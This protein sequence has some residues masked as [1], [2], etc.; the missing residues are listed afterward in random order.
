MAV[1]RA[2]VRNVLIL[3]AAAALV[4]LPS[5]DV[6]SFDRDEAFTV[7]QVVQPDLGDTLEAIPSET[8][9]PLYYVL[10]WL[11]QRVFGSGEVSMRSLSALA[12]VATVP[13]AYELGR[14]LVSTRAAVIIAALV[15]FN[16]MLFWF[17]QEARPYSLLVFL[18]SV[19]LL[20]TVRSVEKPDLLNLGMWVAASALA[21]ATHWFAAFLILPQA[22]W[23]LVRTK[24]RR[25]VA[26]VV[27]LAVVCA[28]LLPLLIH[29]AGHG[30][31]AWIGIF[32]LGERLESTGEQFLAGPPGA[33]LAPWAAIGGVLCAIG[34]A[35][36]VARAD[37]AER[38]GGLVALAFGGAALLIPLAIDVVGPNYFVDK[39]VMPALVP[40]GLAVAAGLGA[41]RAGPAGIAIAVALCGIS[42]G[43]VAKM[44]FDRDFQRWDWRQAMAAMGKPDRPRAVVAPYNGDASLLLYLG[45]W[46]RVV[47]G[48]ANVSEIVVFGWADPRA[49]QLPDGFKQVERREL[50]SFPMTRY[51]AT[52][53]VPVDRQALATI[54][55]GG[56]CN[57]SDSARGCEQA[58]VVLDRR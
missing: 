32:G 52:A 51:R 54:D 17:S 39:N 22:V 34:L 24:E 9:P 55:M 35:L 57:P 23:I 1:Q 3:T 40:L 41:R 18:C 31:A 2:D 47:K 56:V 42:L 25:A 14:R 43:L 30:G 58:T 12:G 29:Q 28:P 38:R 16:P 10:T 36:L 48:D 27:V 37:T 11:V 4:R 26:A 15:A 46:E 13:V 7:A 49:I 8:S 5:L 50:Q 45:R 6:Q 21:F 19:S 20:F 44:T 33:R 53:P